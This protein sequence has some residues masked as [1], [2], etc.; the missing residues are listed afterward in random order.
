MKLIVNNNQYKRLIRQQNKENNFLNEWGVYIKDN[1]IKKIKDKNLNENVISLNNLN[2]KLSK[3]KFFNSLPMDN[4]ILNIYNERLNETIIEL[5]NN[6]MYLDESN[7]IKD[8]FINII[9]NNSKNLNETIN[10]SEIG[11]KLMK[12]KE[13][14]ET[15][16]K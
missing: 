9:H 15:K 7:K 11:I 2:L 3:H 1:I 16:N 4:L 8:V 13:W 10:S 6:T 12:I 14:Y 5:D